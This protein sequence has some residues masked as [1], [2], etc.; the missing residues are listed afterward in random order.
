M[1]KQR[2]LQSN[3]DSPTAILLPTSADRVLMPDFNSSLVVSDL[4]ISYSKSSAPAVNGLSFQAHGGEAL[5]ILGGNGAGK[6]STLK[7]L[8]GILPPS[9]GTIRLNEYDL[10]NPAQ[11]DAARQ[12]V[13]Y[14]PD[15]GGLV[16]QATVFEHLALLK[17]LRGSLFLS[18]SEVETLIETMGL[19]AHAQIPVGGFSHGMAR[20][21]SVLLAYAAADKMLILDEPFDGVDPL[22]VET[23]LGLI[24][25]AKDRGLIVIIST[26]LL[27]LLTEASD[28]ILV[29]NKGKK[30]E[31][32]RAFVFEGESGAARYKSLLMDSMAVESARVDS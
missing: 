4:H 12:I 7:S 27:S 14:C 31:M 25:T 21:L 20:R 13:G 24:Q 17:S 16:K 18:D 15:I 26:H 3:N 1:V 19:A 6:T 29:M 28:Q 5:G 10:S 30:L 22:G 23:T 8:A 9:S 2:W 11:A 32:E